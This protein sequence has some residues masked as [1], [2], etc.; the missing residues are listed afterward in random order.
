MTDCEAEDVAD[1]VRDEVADPVDDRDD[2]ERAM[3][4]TRLFPVSVCEQYDEE[5]KILC[6]S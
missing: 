3:T 6:K 5:G 4:L 1:I 2:T